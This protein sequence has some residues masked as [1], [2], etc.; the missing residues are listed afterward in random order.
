MGAIFHAIRQALLEGLVHVRGA[1]RYLGLAYLASLALALPL[2]AALA[3]TLEHSF[4]RGETNERMR[5]GFDS[6]WYQ[7]F[8]GRAE[9]LAST[10]DPSIVGIGA[11][12][13]GLDALVT[14]RLLEHNA[15]IVGVGLIYL[16]VWTFLA[17]GLL[18]R[19]CG[20]SDERSFFAQAAHHFPRFAVLAAAAG[21][22]YYVVFGP[23][24]TGLG[25]LV[26]DINR[27]Q[28]DERVHFAWVVGKYAVLWSIAWTISLVFDYARVVAVRDEL[29]P[30]AV[31]LRRALGIVLRN[32]LR[33]YGLSVCLFVLSVAAMMVYWMVAPDAMGGS[34]F[35]ILVA[36]LI[37]QAYLLVRIGLRGMTW[38]A[39]ASMTSLVERDG[40]R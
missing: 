19:F 31:N 6:L 3:T 11:V 39:E 14:G 13:N 1:R 5:D 8:S 36:F 10:F 29:P 17:A 35:G 16:A 23:L 12:F 2:A 28:L 9:G 32:K 4:G 26:D 33:T 40:R 34:P 30:L 7:G 27:E 22:L 24:H 21:L 37:G 18:S 15:A 25:K 20:R 38:A